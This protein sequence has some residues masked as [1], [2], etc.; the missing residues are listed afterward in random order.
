MDT[1][2]IPDELPEG[3]EPVEAQLFTLIEAWIAST[4]ILLAGDDLKT[5]MFID[6]M[7]TMANGFRG[8]GRGALANHIDGW[9]SRIELG[10]SELRQA[11]NNG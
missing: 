3:I 4:V 11:I 8:G 6:Y 7:E 2:L 5:H 10:T 1:L 9:V